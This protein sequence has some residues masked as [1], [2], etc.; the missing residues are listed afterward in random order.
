MNNYK[1]KFMVSFS[2]D[3]VNGDDEIERLKF[4]KEEMDNNLEC[5][6]VPEV[7]KSNN[8]WKKIFDGVRFE[9]DGYEYGI[10]VYEVEGLLG[11]PD[12]N[13]VPDWFSHCNDAWEK[14][15]SVALMEYEEV[16]SVDMDEVCNKK[17]K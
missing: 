2:F 16:S 7:K 11:L 9:E 6:E 4:I 13:S 10:V 12:W 3:D 1:I 8:K 14:R 15:F 5:I 17:T